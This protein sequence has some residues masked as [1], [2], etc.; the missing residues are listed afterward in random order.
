MTK[1]SPSSDEQVFV[2]WSGASSV[3]AVRAPPPPRRRRAEA[4]ARVDVADSS[5][6]CPLR[7][8]C[9]DNN[10]GMFDTKPKVSCQTSLCQTD[11][12]TASQSDQGFKPCDRGPHA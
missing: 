11:T 12:R 10:Y 5:N 1:R 6:T 3:Q 4:A 2:C 9:H 7:R 8:P